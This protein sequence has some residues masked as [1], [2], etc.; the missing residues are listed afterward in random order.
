V[1][2]D[3]AGLEASK[4]KSVAAIAVFTA[5]SDRQGL[6]VVAAETEYRYVVQSNVTYHFVLCLYVVQP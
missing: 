4:T 5:D 2:E 3:A 1:R 6:I